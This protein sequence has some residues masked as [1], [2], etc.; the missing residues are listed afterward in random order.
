MKRVFYILTT[1]FFLLH[2]LMAQKV[3]RGPYT[4]EVI[5]DG[6]YHIQDYNSVR[7]RGMYTNAQGQASNNNCSDMYLIVGSSKALLIDLS[8]DIKWADNSAESLRSLVSEYSKG[9]DLFISIT[10]NHGDHLGMLHAFADDANANFWVPKADFSEQGLFPE[11]RT[12]FFEENASIDLGGT[13]LK[14]IIVEGHTSGSTIF[15]VDGKDIVFSGDAIGSGSGVWLFSAQSFAQYKQG[16]ANLISYIDN[17]A[18]GINREKLII[19]GGHTWQGTALW[20]LGVQYIYDMAELI[21]RI[22][23]NGDYETTPMAGNPIL[24]TNYK[25]GTAT[26]TWSRTSEK[27]YRESIR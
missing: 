19:Y 1:L 12:V 6:I 18:N 3:E 5:S 21:N 20:P 24:D 7:G 26:I 4:L 17:T 23:Q 13:K 25:Y 11:N 27:A 8:N 16:V 10:H 22:D 2:S 9:R 14:T 15:F